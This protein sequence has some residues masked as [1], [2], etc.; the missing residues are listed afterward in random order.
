MA[1]ELITRKD[2]QELLTENNKKIVEDLGEVF[3]TKTDFESFKE[4]YKQEFSRV[5]N[6]ADKSAEEK[7][8]EEQ[9]ATMLKNK[10]DR[11]EKWIGQI[12]KKVDLKLEA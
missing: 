9:E 12:A 10:V 1:K 2:I 11:H 5:L 8:V 4:E 7:T 6:P 3:V